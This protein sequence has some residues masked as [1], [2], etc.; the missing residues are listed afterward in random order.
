MLD[1]LRKNCPEA[2]MVYLILFAAIGLLACYLLVPTDRAQVRLHSWIRRSKLDKEL[3]AAGDHPEDKRGDARQSGPFLQ[4]AVYD[5][6]A[7]E[8]IQAYLYDS[9]RGG[10]GLVAEQWLPRGRE[11]T[12]L[13]D[14][15]QVKMRVRNCSRKGD[16]WVAG[17]EFTEPLPPALAASLG[18]P[19]D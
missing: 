19:H 10:A 7:Q 8:T 9:S 17:C 5:P 6:V 13:V 1:L 2:K 16:Q 15:Q 11:L 4:A 18:L 14:G 12:L 3:A